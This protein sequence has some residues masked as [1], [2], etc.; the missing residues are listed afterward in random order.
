MIFSEIAQ[1]IVKITEV[2]PQDWNLPEDF[3]VA[4]LTYMQEWTMSTL[5][6]V[7]KGLGVQSCGDED[8][9]VEK[10]KATLEGDLQ[11]EI[12]KIEN[13]IRTKSK[14]FTLLYKSANGLVATAKSL[15]LMRLGMILDH[16]QKS[17]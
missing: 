15:G 9:W 4:K 6:T 8:K 17:V 11:G 2:K 3:K 16:M 7:D 1:P 14:D 13:L 5:A 12:D 10:L